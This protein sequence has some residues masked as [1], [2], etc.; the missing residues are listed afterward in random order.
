MIRVL[1]AVRMRWR[2]CIAQKGIR[3]IHTWFWSGNLKDLQDVSMYSTTI[4]KWILKKMD[5][6][7]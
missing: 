6:Q 7:T 4:L 3:E 1:K 2:Q 5:E